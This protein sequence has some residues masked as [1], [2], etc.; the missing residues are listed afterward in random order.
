VPD[1]LTYD[2]M[3]A[4]HTHGGQIRLPGLV[5]KVIPTGYPFDRGLHEPTIGDDTRLVYVTS[6][7]GMVGLPMRFNMPPRI[8][9]LTVKLPAA[10]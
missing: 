9:L 8:D 3:L 4:G 7:T 1:S 10:D 2:L 5:Q 6:G